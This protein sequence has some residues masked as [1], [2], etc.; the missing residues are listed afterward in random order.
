[1]LNVFP[2]EWWLQDSVALFAVSY[3]VFTA[4]FVRRRTSSVDPQLSTRYG[5]LAALAYGTTIFLF[6][7]ALAAAI[8]VAIRAWGTGYGEQT[9]VPLASNIILYAHLTML[10]LIFVFRGSYAKRQ[11]V[12][13]YLAIAIPRIIVSLAGSRFFSFQALIPI[14][15]VELWIFRPNGKHLTKTILA[16]AIG[17]FFALVPAILRGSESRLNAIELFVLGNASVN[18]AKLYDQSD[19]IQGHSSLIL[20][21]LFASFFSNLLPADYSL[22]IWG[23]KKLAFRFDRALSFEFVPDVEQSGRGTGGNF[24]VELFHDGGQALVLIAGAL[25]AWL[26][27]R[28]AALFVRSPAFRFT[29]PHVVAKLIFLPRGTIVE[30]LDRWI[31]LLLI[32]MSFIFIYQI[33]RRLRA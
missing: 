12:F 16:I 7:L 9:L 17:I 20:D 26:S 18:V 21:G 11:L 29:F 2:S 32:F 3:L 13:A 6:P 1:V 31:I 10:G 22:T 28:S 15:I 5:R 33:A 27:Q 8:Y 24:L 19:L 4:V 30:L 23:G 14:A 25:I